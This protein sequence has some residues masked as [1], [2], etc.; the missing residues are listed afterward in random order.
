MAIITISIKRFGMVID[1]YTGEHSEFGPECGGT[2]TSDMKCSPQDSSHNE[3]EQAARYNDMMDALES[4]I[5]AHAVAGIEVSSPVYVEG[6]QT[7]C[8]ACAKATE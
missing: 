8:D 1:L 2:I 5:L 6:I 3:E 4:L 7:A